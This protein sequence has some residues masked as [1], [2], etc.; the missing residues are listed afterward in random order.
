MSVQGTTRWCQIISSDARQGEPQHN[1]SLKKL[2]TYAFY[3]TVFSFCEYTS[4][5]FS[6][7]SM[8]G[9]LRLHIYSTAK[10]VAQENDLS[11]ANEFTEVNS[12]GFLVFD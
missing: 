4:D 6:H 5:F 8:E 12:L 2:K 1:K 10:V 11:L 9:N 7:S 3:V